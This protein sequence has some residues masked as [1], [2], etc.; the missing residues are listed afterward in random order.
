[1][2]KKNIEVLNMKELEELSVYGGNDAE[3]A[4][5]SAVASAVAASA[6]LT[7]IISALTAV[8]TLSVGVSELFSCAKKCK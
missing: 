5:T 1:M 8:T 4:P 2:E 7:D 6:T 3:I